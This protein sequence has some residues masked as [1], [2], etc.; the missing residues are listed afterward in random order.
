MSKVIGPT[1]ENALV[2]IPTYNEK[3]ALPLIVTRVRDSV[4]EVD[5]RS[6]G[7]PLLSTGPAST[8]WRTS[9]AV[10]TAESHGPNV[11]ASRRR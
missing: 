5:G 11:P 2:V 7:N 9:T 6:V 1:G 3:D 4:P 8:V 10:E